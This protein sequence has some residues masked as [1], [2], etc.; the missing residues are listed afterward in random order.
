MCFYIWAFSVSVGNKI[1]SFGKRLG[2]ISFMSSFSTQA[3]TLNNG[4]E[5]ATMVRM[6]K[7]HSHSRSQVLSGGK[8]AVE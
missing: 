5:A 3:E 6:S 2:A 4:S 8:E 7:W 1:I